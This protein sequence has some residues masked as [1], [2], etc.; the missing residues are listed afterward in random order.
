MTTLLG[1]M[2]LPG[3]GLVDL[4]VCV[5]MFYLSLHRVQISGSPSTMTLTPLL[6]DCPTVPRIY[7]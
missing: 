3:F 1:L 7:H 4:S 6:T 2:L 5:Q